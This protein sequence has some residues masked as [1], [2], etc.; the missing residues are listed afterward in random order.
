MDVKSIIAKNISELRQ[1]AG[2][3]QI[4]LAEKLNYSDKSV[5]KWE[6]G[7]SVPDV[8]VLMEI[9][10]MFGVTLDYLVEEEHTA[11]TSAEM[12]G[13]K[14]A[15][16]RKTVRN[17][18]FITGMCILLVWL[19]AAMAFVV[20]DIVPSVNYGHFLAFAYAVP[21]SMIVWLIFNAIWFDK[22]RNFLIISLLMWSFLAS[23]C[24]SFSIL[25]GMNIWLVMIL[26]VFGQA[27]ILL[28]S[29]LLPS[30]E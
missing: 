10:S 4:D 14:K 25:G 23:F 8:T 22:R 7:E 2:M 3:T 12:S 11:K 24:L 29:K 13:G 21:V 27:I 1:S 9:S 28:W 5:S 18:G 19:I 17:R 20:C 30:A 6:R 15:P 16:S 26:G